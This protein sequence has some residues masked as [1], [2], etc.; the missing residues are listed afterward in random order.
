MRATLILILTFALS[1]AVYASSLSLDRAHYLQALSALKEGRY[2][3]FD[4]L[5][6]TERGYIARPYLRYHYLMR[7]IRQDKPA[8][9]AQFLSHYPHLP[10]TPKLHRAW[11]Q[12][13]ARH[14]RDR[15][16]LRFY[17]RDWDNNVALRCDDLAARV[18]LKQDAGVALAV[19]AVWLTGR[20]LPRSC[21][22]VTAS[23][24]RSGGA[25][26]ANLWARAKLAMHAHNVPLMKRLLPALAPPDALWAR[27]W[28]AM[29]AHPA[30]VLAKL[31]YALVT[32]MARH[33]V[34]SGIVTLGY[35]SPT[36][37]MTVWQHLRL[38]QPVLAED[39]NFV[40]RGLGL[41]GAE[42]HLPQALSWL[43]AAVPTGQGGGRLRR[44]R[45]RA[46]LRERS[47]PRVL[48]FIDALPPSWRRQHKWQ[49]WRARA[50]AKTG[51]VQASKKIFK[52][53]AGH[54][55][56]YGFL[57]A[58]RLGLP[59]HIPNVPLTEPAVLQK[60]VGTLYGVRLAHELYRLH[61]HNEAR[62]L[63]FAT[64]R[65]LPE[66]QIETAGLLAASWGWQDCAILT[67]AGTQAVHALSIRFPLLY[68]PLIEADAHQNGIDPA[69][70]YGI[71]RQES[72]FI[73]D[74][75]S[76]VGA[77]GLMQLMPQ[78]G[79]ITAREIH[80]PITGDRDL[81]DANTNIDVGTRYL[82]DVLT[83]ARREEPVATAAY[84]AGPTAAISWLPVKRPLAADIWIDT[85]PY[86]QTRGYVKNVLTF[87]AIYNYLLKGH[88]NTLKTR[89][90][91]IPPAVE[92]A[93]NGS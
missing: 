44:W 29:R 50:L 61:A 81:I 65:G 36:L 45:I 37:A 19:R 93:A 57:A 15:T 85:I 43:A 79:F 1:S 66:A 6:A 41:I 70:V 87:T 31:H 64:L 74:A 51:H 54:F 17:T 55:G 25:T 56:Y 23:W 78:T 32:P 24:L 42:E 62:A 71:I 84:N 92:L 10:I 48:V 72:A 53:L 76:N 26:E 27:R 16:F 86:R 52:R 67:V 47:W 89:M 4:A 80:L 28:M 73:I 38:K 30:H 90:A 35:R 77:L 14:H 7:R 20:S 63:W 91:P 68:R 12:F 9:I 59:Y 2:T 88:Q 58:D 8:E 49:Y 69:W 3:R 18:R 40:L 21:Q 13:L 11:L 83:R 75:R 46:A 5:Y 33:I 39:N 82:A 34:R 22:T 60:A